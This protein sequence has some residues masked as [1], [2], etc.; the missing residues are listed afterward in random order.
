MGLPRLFFRQPSPQQLPAVILGHPAHN[1]LLLPVHILP[2]ETM[3]ATAENMGDVLGL[4]N[5]KGMRDMGDSDKVLQEVHF[6]KK[7]SFPK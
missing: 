5:K 6:L 7:A 2:R 4:G 1:K 3:T